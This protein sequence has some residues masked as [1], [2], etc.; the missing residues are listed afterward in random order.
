MIRNRI[1]LL[2]ELSA[3]LSLFPLR[4][5]AQTQEL[6]HGHLNRGLDLTY[7]ADYKGAIRE[8][9]AALALDTI[10]P[11]GHL[12]KAACLET[13]MIDYDSRCHE[14]EFYSLI[15][16]AERKAEA[17]LEENPE[18]GWD[19]FYLGTCHAYRAVHDIFFK[20]SYLSGVTHGF[21]TIREFERALN[22]DPGVY[23]AYLGKGVFDWGVGKVVSRIPFV[24]R[25]VE[26][27]VSDVERAMRNGIYTRVPARAVLA[28]MF[29]I[30]ERNDMALEHAELLASEYRGSRFFQNLLGAMYLDMEEYDLSERAWRAMLELTEGDSLAFYPRAAAR[31]GLARCQF[32]RKEMHDCAAICRVAMDAPRPDTMNRRLRSDLEELEKLMER[33]EKEIGR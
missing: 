12:F 31:L 3:L 24:H 4:I 2:F 32:A 5:S 11:A 25:S 21:K 27:A 22:A 18:S 26:E 14:D 6:F 16:L 10:S 13:Y 29:V 20:G 15:D 17:Q 33:A 7:R 1:F 19:R 8:F 28:W 30:D 23:D 9:D